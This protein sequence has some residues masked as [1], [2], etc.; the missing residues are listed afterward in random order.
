VLPVLSHREGVVPCHT[1]PYGSPSE[2]NYSHEQKE[3]V[4]FVGHLLVTLSKY[5]RSPTVCASVV[6]AGDDEDE[7]LEPQ[8]I[9]TSNSFSSA[10]TAVSIPDANAQEASYYHPATSSHL[11]RSPAAP[12]VLDSPQLFSIPRHPSSIFSFP[13]PTTYAAPPDPTAN[14]TPVAQGSASELFKCI[15]KKP[16]VVQ[17]EINGVG[18]A[19]VRV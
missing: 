13:T 3:L 5:R 10:D 7:T 19:Y 4:V 16:E 14:I 11:Y 6:H 17:L 9:G 12:S 2:P 1:S 15:V 8:R 18:F